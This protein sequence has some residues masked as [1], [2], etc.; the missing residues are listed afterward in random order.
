MKITKNSKAVLA[1]K[2]SLSFDLVLKCCVCGCT[3]TMSC[4]K[5]SGRGA[6][7]VRNQVAVKARR[8]TSDSK[9]DPSGSGSKSGD[10]Y[11]LSLQD[12]PRKDLE[13]YWACSYPEFADSWVVQ[14]QNGWVAEDHYEKEALDL[15]QGMFWKVG[16]WNA[17]PVYK[18]TDND[19]V[20]W[21]FWDFGW[22]CWVVSK[23]LGMTGKSKID[24][25]NVMM[26]TQRLGVPEPR[27]PW[28]KETAHKGIKVVA[29]SEFW[30]RFAAEL[31][32]K[33]AELTVNP[34]DLGEGAGTCDKSSGTL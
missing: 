31:T 22:N 4:S 10:H 32:L 30:Q 1:P 6:L 11:N 14:V 33:N 13:A 28:W 26:T 7:K 18:C 15:V 27:L 17:T 12:T 23:V 19:Q 8:H 9:K 2:H 29:G 16:Y 20:M 3:H 5:S 21:L 34:E 25:C 24:N